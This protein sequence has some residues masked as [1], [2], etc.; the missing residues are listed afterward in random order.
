MN[1]IIHILQF[2]LKLNIVKSLYYS[3]RFGG[4]VFIGKG[5]IH[6]EGNGKIDFRT[7]AS[8][9]FI[10][11]YHTIPTATTIT[12]MQNARLVVGAN[13]K[14]H[15]GTKIVVHEGGTLEIGDNTYINEL[16]RVHCRKNITI[17]NDCAIAWSINIL[18]TDLHTIYDE[19]GQP[20]NT[21][22]AIHIGNKVWIGANTTVLKG[23]CIEDN[24]II[25]AQSVVHGKVEG[26]YI[27]AGNPLKQIKTF[28]TW[29]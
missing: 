2:V 1:R 29:N 9:L 6:I 3:I 15:R 20:I 18:D 27:Y 19:A 22:Q 13:A 4:R 23:T 10:G 21:D 11:V 8:S 5:N 17:G 25:A 16:A 28:A 12:L 7:K 14:I 24:S 26:N